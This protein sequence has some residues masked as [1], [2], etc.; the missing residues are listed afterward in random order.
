VH[1]CS[2][3]TAQSA[4]PPQRP[5]LSTT[6]S[7]S[8]LSGS[9]PLPPPRPV[10][11]LQ[12]RAGVG[13]ELAC[14]WEV[15]AQFAPSCRA[16]VSWLRNGIGVPGSCHGRVLGWSGDPVRAGI[17]VFSNKFGIWN[18]VP[19]SHD[20]S[21]LLVAINIE[22]EHADEA[23]RHCP[24]PPLQATFARPPLNCAGRTPRDQP[25]WHWGTHLLSGDAG[26]AAVDPAQSVAMAT[27]RWWGP[28]IGGETQVV[29]HPGFGLGGVS[30]SR[31]RPRRWLWVWDDLILGWDWPAAPLPDGT[32]GSSFGTGTAAAGLLPAAGHPPL[33]A[34]TVIG[35]TSSVRWSAMTSKWAQK[36]GQ[37]LPPK[38]GHPPKSDGLG[39]GCLE[40]G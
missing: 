11:A 14:A 7:A 12:P 19:I 15:F 20:V 40:G 31:C 1:D 34:L 2:S 8:A 30:T 21:E 6:A 38:P 17:R 22:A 4:V 25:A 28:G 13:P 29:V 24:V 18:R 10:M 33:A 23:G 37:N 39:E 36:L 16:H 27:A 35:H 26:P 32:D 3:C 5:T 9:V